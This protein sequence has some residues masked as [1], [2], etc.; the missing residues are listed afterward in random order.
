MIN[1]P[2]KI[3]A[4]KLNFK[5]KP[6]I[7]SFK[8]K[9]KPQLKK[10]NRSLLFKLM[11][12]TSLFLFLMLTQSFILYITGNIQEFLD[13]TQTFILLVCSM[14]SVTIVL[15]SIYGLVES[16]VL[17]FLHKLKRYWI[18]FSLFFMSALISAFIF[19]FSR[20][21]IY[22]SKGIS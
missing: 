19:I 21:V 22:L 7:M 20:G 4:R 18:Y 10:I 12:R 13:S 6:I 3:P 14:L 11:C 17:F 15:I 1:H 9:I 16:V 2:I 5:P 8:V